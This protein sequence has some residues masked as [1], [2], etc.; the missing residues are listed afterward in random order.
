MSLSLRA[1]TMLKATLLA[2][3]ATMPLH[4][5][6]NQND[7]ANKV[8]DGSAIF[9]DP[10]SCP[11][12][13]YPSGVLSPYGAEALPFVHSMAELGT[14]DFSH[15][16][17]AYYKAMKSYPDEGVNGYAGRLNHVPKMFI[18]NREK[19][20][21]DWTE[22]H[23]EDSQAQGISKVALIV[24]R[25]A[26]HAEL[27]H[28][29]TK[30]VDVLQI[31]PISVESSVLLA[32]LLERILFKHE[33]PN[34]AITSLLRDADRVQLTPWQRH[35]LGF[36]TSDV[37][38]DEYVRFAQSLSSLPSPPEDAY[39]SMRINGKVLSQYFSVSHPGLTLQDAF[40]RA[41]VE[42]PDSDRDILSQAIANMS[43]QEGESLDEH[44]HLLRVSRSFGL[45]C[46]LPSAILCSL[47]ILRKSR[48]LEE[49][50]RTNILVGGD[51]CSRSMVIAAAFASLGEQVDQAVIQAWENKVQENWWRPVV[52][53]I[54]KIVQGNS[55]LHN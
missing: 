14:F 6:Y 9:Y 13:S 52:E 11:F 55:A 25:Y 28:Q 33:T 19:E 50:I 46:V 17:E 49:A 44:Q 18:E 51:N 20:H 37:L 34:A 21:K 2:D 32:K 48:S 4:W 15:V 24:A 7:L 16:A 47:H 27:S 10:P 53:S 26:G 36:V 22:C 45:S 5:I 23:V 29:V 38:I 40:A 54:D 42:L 8:G 35:L 39:R 43:Q 1:S 3:A 12:Y 31:S 41:Q 30:M